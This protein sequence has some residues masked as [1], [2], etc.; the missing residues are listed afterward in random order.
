M[1]AKR[2]IAT[3]G[4]EIC[5][6]AMELAGGAAFF[7]GSPIE[8]AYRDIRA[9]KFHPLTPEA[10]L[11]HAGRQARPYRLSGTNGLVKVRFWPR[12]VGLEEPVGAVGGNGDRLN[13]SLA[14]KLGDPG[15]R[16]EASP[17]VVDGLG[18]VVGEH[19]VV[20]QGLGMKGGHDH[21]APCDA[22]QFP[23]AGRGIVP[24][25]DGEDRQRRIY[26]LTIQGK[27]L[28]AG[29]DCRGEVART[30]R[31]HDLRR[32]ECQNITILGLIRA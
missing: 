11:L 29:R 10:T 22:P 32:L 4:V 9:A 2:E 27:V 8:R 17:V 21:W 15:D 20:L 26:A 30:L 23:E 1:A 16:G 19:P 14:E 7:K 3:A 28:R 31:A 5:D 18:Q 24:M 13:T 12:P 6:L 25:V